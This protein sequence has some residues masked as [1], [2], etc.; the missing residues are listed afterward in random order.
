MTESQFDLNDVQIIADEIGY[1][2]HL[3]VSV[4]RLRHKLFEGGWSAEIQRE[5]VRRGDAVSVILYDPAKEAVVLVEQFRIGGIDDDCPWML[6]LVAGVV[7]PGEDIETVAQRETEEEAGL[8][9]GSS[10]LVYQYYTTAGICSERVSLFY[11]ECDSSQARMM[12][13]LPEENEDIRVHVVPLVQAMQWVR[14]GKIKNVN[15][16]IGL[17]WL[18]YEKNKAR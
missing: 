9:I 11:A 17:Q 1:Q 14:Q 6:E 5:L 8:K 2:G 10:E 18:F 7:E 4:I 16:L 3:S 15:T 12:A 13:G